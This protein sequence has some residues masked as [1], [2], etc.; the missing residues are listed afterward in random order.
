[1]GVPGR[2]KW[3]SHPTACYNLA[4]LVPAANRRSPVCIKTRDTEYT[5]FDFQLLSSSKAV[6]AEGSAIDFAPVESSS[7]TAF[8]PTIVIGGPIPALTGSESGYLANSTYPERVDDNDYLLALR[9]QQEE[10]E[11]EERRAAALR[12]PKTPDPIYHSNRPEYTRPIISNPY[13]HRPQGDA[14]SP[15]MLDV[16]AEQ[17]RALTF[18]Q[19]QMAADSA[20]EHSRQTFPDHAARTRQPPPSSSGAACLIC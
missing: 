9:L 13:D 4:S 16:Y 20:R 2:V 11:E 5:G 15:P 7:T 6:C 1:M 3:V 14:L 17:E 8:A 10:E 19:Q 12:S 18:Y